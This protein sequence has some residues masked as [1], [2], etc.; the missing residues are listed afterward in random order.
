MKA[1]VPFAIEHFKEH[2]KY[3]SPDIVEL[4]YQQFEGITW[5]MQ[6]ILNTLFS[7]TPTDGNAT[8]AMVKEAIEKKR[9][10]L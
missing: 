6:K 5:Y 3:L 7:M 2:S 9:K 8:A 1:Y 4:V 10:F